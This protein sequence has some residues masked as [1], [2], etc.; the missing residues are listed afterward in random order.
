MCSTFYRLWLFILLLNYSPIYSYK[1]QKRNGKDP[2]ADKAIPIEYI[3]LSFRSVPFHSTTMAFALFRRIIRCCFSNY[4]H[5][6]LFCLCLLVTKHK[7]ISSQLNCVTGKFYNSV[8]IALTHNKQN[9]KE[10]KTEIIN[11]G[12]TFLLYTFQCSNR[13]V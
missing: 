8:A 1:V 13:S 7:C 3:L 9:G 6:K 12:K 11:L 10:H 4:V 2:L 5:Y